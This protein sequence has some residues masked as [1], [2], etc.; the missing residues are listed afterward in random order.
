M[1][2]RK[3]LFFETGTTFGISLYTIVLVVAFILH[4]SCSDLHKKGSAE[5]VKTAVSNNTK[6]KPPSSFSDTLQVDQPSIIFYTPDSL[7]LEKI[8]AV[9]DS[10]VFSSTMHEL[11]Y[12]MRNSRIVLGKNYPQ[13][14][15]YEVKNSR[16]IDFKK[17][18]GV[19]DCIDLNKYDDPC[20][21]FIFDARKNPKLVDMTN[22][23]TEL[24]FYFTK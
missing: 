10:G 18:V 13:I 2:M 8:R 21:M 4:S 9:T 11:V 15:I 6:H 5:T 1:E 24:G 14:R 12:Q 7:Q 22:I 16:F 3:P 23:E 20:G 17:V 19:D